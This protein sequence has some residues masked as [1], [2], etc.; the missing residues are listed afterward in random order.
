MSW[1]IT[2]VVVSVAVT[3]GFICRE[4][5][6]RLCVYAVEFYWNQRSSGRQGEL[7]STRV[8]LFIVM[9][10]SF[11]FR[12]TPSPC[13]GPPGL[14]LMQWIKQSGRCE[15]LTRGRGLPLS[16][17]TGGRTELWFPPGS[18]RY[19]IPRCHLPPPL[20]ALFARSLNTYAKWLC[21]RLDPPLLQKHNLHSI[22]SQSAACVFAWQRLHE[23]M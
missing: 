22:D 4:V 3:C 14:F 20:Y 17:C 23:K 6:V 19:L 16:K 15:H 12:F 21:F 8:H 9:S 2:A 1:P 18:V 5:E 7:S 10:F 13:S 11:S